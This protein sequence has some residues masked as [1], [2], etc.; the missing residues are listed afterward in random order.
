MKCYS[1]IKIN[2]LQFHTNIDQSYK[3]RLSKKS[4]SQNNTFCVNRYILWHG[5]RNHTSNYLLIQV[6]QIWLYLTYK[7]PLGWTPRIS[8]LYYVYMHICMYIV[9]FLFYLFFLDIL[10]SILIDIYPTFFYPTLKH[11]LSEDMILFLWLFTEEVNN[12][13]KNWFGK[14][15]AWCDVVPDQRQ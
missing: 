3:H 1:E 4:Q 9:L 12:S 6:L 5:F 15:K 11:T 8:V 10:I 2:E 13:T 7:I 14:K